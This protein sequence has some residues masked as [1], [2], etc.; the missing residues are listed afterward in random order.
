MLSFSCGD[1]L[2]REPLQKKKKVRPDFRAERFSDCNP[3]VWI[4]REH[5]MRVIRNE[6]HSGK[7]NE[8]HSRMRV[9]LTAK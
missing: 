3:K 6:G 2:A 4:V 8:G 7:Q 9:I 5:R 1:T